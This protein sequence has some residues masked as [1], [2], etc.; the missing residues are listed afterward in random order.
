MSKSGGVLLLVLRLS[1]RDTSLVS[2]FSYTFAQTKVPDSS[3]TGTHLETG[4]SIDAQSQGLQIFYEDDDLLQAN[5]A[6]ITGFEMDEYG[7]YT[8]IWVRGKIKYK[9]ID[10]PNNHHLRC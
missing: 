10:S 1:R 2:T 4:S 8:N 9:A 6:R 3:R 5:R 7:S